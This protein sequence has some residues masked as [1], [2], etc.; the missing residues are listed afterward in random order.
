MYSPYWENVQSILGKWQCFKLEVCIVT[1]RNLFVWW[2]LWCQKTLCIWRHRRAPPRVGG[3]TRHC[4]VRHRQACSQR[5]NPCM[6][7]PARA[8]AL[9]ERLRAPMHSS[10]TTRARSAT[11]FDPQHGVVVME[12]WRQCIRSMRIGQVALSNSLRFLHFQS[13]KHANITRE[14]DIVID[15][16][17]DLFSI[18]ANRFISRT[19]LARCEHTCT[20]RVKPWTYNGPW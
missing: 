1:Y 3:Q 9:T 18:W 17:S 10:R 12:T 5:A 16:Y 15:K 13:I 11:S 8:R 7:G 14:L 6:P 2:S 19:E 4:H 20:Y